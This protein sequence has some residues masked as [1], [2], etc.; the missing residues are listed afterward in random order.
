MRIPTHATGLTALAAAVLIAHIGAQQAAPAPQIPQPIYRAPE[1]TRKTGVKPDAIKAGV[2]P[3]YTKLR[4]QLVVIPV[5]GRV[6]LIGGAGANIAVQ[7]SDEGTL[8]VDAGDSAAT[9]KVLAEIKK[10]QV[11]PIRWII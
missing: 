6:H 2:R 4:D 9:D 5:Q 11:R 8:V 3:D 7:V 1:D 10:L